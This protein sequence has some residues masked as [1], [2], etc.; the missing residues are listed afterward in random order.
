MTKAPRTERDW[1]RKMAIKLFNDTWTLIDKRRRTPA[2]ID[3]M[4]HSAHASRYHWSKVGTPTNF[5][6]G[7]W[8][9]SHVY[10]ILGRAEPSLYHARHC[11]E[12]C[13]RHDLGDFVLAFAHEA[14]ARAYVV[15]GQVL[16][17]R[18]HLALGMRAGRDIAEEDDRERFFGDLKGI[19]GLL[20]RKRPARRRTRARR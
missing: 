5:A 18:R 15:S 4:I 6:I 16:E 9:L 8:Q 1:H 7:E 12:L 10:A 20:A 3:A 2:E 14:N 17:A 19:E 13:Q 11:L